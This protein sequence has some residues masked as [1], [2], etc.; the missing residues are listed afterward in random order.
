MAFKHDT[1]AAS[2][3][4]GRPDLLI[5]EYLAAAARGDVGAYFDLGVAFSTGS[6]G[7]PIDLIEAHKWFN[8]AAAMGH[9]KAAYCRADLSDEMSMREIAEAQRRARQWLAVPSRKAA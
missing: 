5:T 7:T 6:H 2:V 3:A 8:I 9:G 4:D 1:E